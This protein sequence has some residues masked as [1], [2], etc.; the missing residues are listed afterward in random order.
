MEYHVLVL[1]INFTA[2]FDDGQ[3]ENHL[4]NDYIWAQCATFKLDL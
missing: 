1:Y 2:N 3:V 4:Y